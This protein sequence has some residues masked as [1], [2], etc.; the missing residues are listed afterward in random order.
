MARVEP[1]AYGMPIMV[2]TAE[3][4]TLPSQPRLL[5]QPEMEVVLQVAASLPDSVEDHV[6]ISGE[7][8][9]VEI[10]RHGHQVE[11]LDPPDLE[12]GLLPR[13]EELC[14]LHHPDGLRESEQN[15]S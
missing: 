1:R 8:I 2:F 11:L 13:F 5:T 15:D 4:R 6:G 14:M 10:S 12:A 3:L 9:P 7:E